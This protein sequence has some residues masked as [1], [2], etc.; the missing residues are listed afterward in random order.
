MRPLAN[1]APLSPRGER[2]RGR[3]GG[4]GGILVFLLLCASFAQADRLISVPTARKLLDGAYRLESLRRFGRGT[5][6]T[7]YFAAGL[8]PAWEAEA[9]LFERSDRATVDLGYNLLSPFP[10]LAP[11]FAFGLQD[12]FD[13]THSGRRLFLCG[14]IRNEFGRGGEAFDVT[15]GLFA[16][17]RVTPYVGASVPL[18]PGLRLLVEHDGY[19]GQAA[20]EAIPFRGVR[21]RL[22]SKGG[23]ALGSLGF[24]ARF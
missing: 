20:L 21:L 16:G 19:V 1:L 4:K 12:A 14:T 6:A 9:R 5:E 10:G 17:R 2:G 7:D 23:A 24:T 8:G 15:V 18:R 13:E 22:V 11:G 3:G